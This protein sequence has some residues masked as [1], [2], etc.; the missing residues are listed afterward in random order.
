MISY[1]AMWLGLTNFKNF[2]GP[3]RFAFEN[4]AFGGY[5]TETFVLSVEKDRVRSSEPG[6]CP[7]SDV[8]IYNQR[9]IADAAP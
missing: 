2:T 6:H 5:H 3:E 4:T 1:C 7:L 8:K 9:D